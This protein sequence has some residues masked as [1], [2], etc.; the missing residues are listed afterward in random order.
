MHP[1][2]GKKQ[3]PE[4]IAKRV[5]SAAGKPRKPGA[6]KPANTPEV[7][8]SKVEKRGSDECWPWRGFRNKQGY[9]RTWIND[10][11]YYAH[12]IIFDLA[13]PGII[14][15]SNHERTVCVMHTCDN[16]PC[17]N[18]AHLKL[19]T[20][21]DNMDDKVSKGRQ[22][23]FGSV[24]SPRAK[25]TAEDV[26]WIRIQNNYATKRALALLHDVSEATISGCLYGR[27]YQDIP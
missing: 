11:G 1:L 12:R 6:G 8:W 23:R 21:Q 20:H 17:C 13:N 2:K 26:A 22:A 5:A 7:L 15:L 14:P 27:Y 25:L 18:P 24:N 10:T 16:P 19:G 9:G 3:S 4:H